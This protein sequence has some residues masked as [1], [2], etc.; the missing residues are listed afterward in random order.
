MNEIRGETTIVIE[1]PVTAVYNY[2][3]DF[4]RHPEWVKNVQKVT[5]L[6]GR[7]AGVGA[8][9]KTQ[10]GVPPVG[11]RQKLKMMLHFMRGVFS[12]AKTYSI[13]EITALE[14]GRRIAWRGGVPKGNGY[15]NISDWE[16]LLESQG[17]AT[18]LTQ[19]FCYR[20]QT[21]VAVSMIGAAGAQG[22][23]QACAVNLGQLKQRLENGTV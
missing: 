12:G 20:P 22:I 7:Q 9:F 18:R 10:E 2:L 1:A 16:V 23:E 14:S 5:P 4:T 8:R 13:A 19:R 17:K 11:P 6:N 3:A 15:F 21:A